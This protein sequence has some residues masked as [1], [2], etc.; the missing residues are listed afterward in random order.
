MIAA[1]N[2]HNS[3]HPF[4]ASALRMAASSNLAQAVMFVPCMMEASSCNLSR[5][6]ENLTGNFR[7]ILQTLLACVA[8]YL[9]T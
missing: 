3:I 2:S 1:S 9:K 5:N 7:N 8:V 4:I 6:T